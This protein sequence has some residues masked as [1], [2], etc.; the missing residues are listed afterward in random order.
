MKRLL[1]IGIAFMVAYAGNAQTD[2][3]VLA[4]SCGGEQKTFVDLGMAVSVTFHGA[5]NDGSPYYSKHSMA[6]HF[7]LMVHYRITPR[8]MFSAGMQY[9]FVRSPLEYRV[10]DISD[11]LGVA[12]STNLQYASQSA[13]VYH[14]Y[15]G[16]P[17]QITWYPTR[18]LS[19]GVSLSFDVH[20]AYAVSQY[21]AIHDFTATP[22]GS[23]GTG[24]ELE[25]DFLNPW[26]LELGVTIGLPRLGLIHGIRIYGDLL[27]TYREYINKKNVYMG[28]ISLFL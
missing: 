8:W 26:K 3:T 6:L 12:F 16:L 21:L 17:V 28:G 13:Y 27:P 11:D 10:K 4:D 9:D 14:F 24:Y 15:A 5:A 18:K 7:P 19:R 22:T 1:L 25:G 2:T 20:P 23:S